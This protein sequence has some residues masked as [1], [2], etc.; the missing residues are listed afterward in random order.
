MSRQEALAAVGECCRSVVCCGGDG[1]FVY[2]K[3]GD[4]SMLGSIQFKD[5][6][7]SDL[8]ADVAASGDKETSDF[9]RALYRVML[10]GQTTTNT[11]VS[12]KVFA[13]ESP[14]ST[15]RNIYLYFP[16]GRIL[17][18]YQSSGDDGS[19]VARIDELR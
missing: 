3:T 2:S 15:L 7:V 9:V 19:V 14:N 11:A 4:Y 18:V 6:R 17:W 10:N 16:D 8:H 1:V 12:I 13:Q 5:G